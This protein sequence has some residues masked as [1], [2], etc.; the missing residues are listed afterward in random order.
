MK[1]VELKVGLFIIITTAIIIGF[2][3]FI[4]EKQ[5]LFEEGETL[6]LTTDSADGISSGMAVTFSGFKIGEI[7]AMKLEDSGKINLFVKIPSHHYKWIN[8][9]S[10]YILNKPLIGSTKILII[11]PDVNEK[12]LPKGK[13]MELLT[14]DSIDD[15]IQKIRPVVEKANEIL[16]NIEK[17]THTLSDKES[18]AAMATGDNSSG[19]DLA[20]ALSKSSK[21]IDS[22]DAT[23]I[24]A[25]NLV[26][27]TDKN[28]YG[29][30]GLM[31]DIRGEDGIISELRASLRKLDEM[32]AN[33][34]KISENV[35]SSSEDLE[36]LKSQIE[37]AIK[38]ANELILEIDSKIPFKDK[39]EIKLP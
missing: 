29:D 32:L 6:I 14:I 33:G 27:N 16:L 31:S 28:L 25:T 30:G 38:N 26:K 36:S 9:S 23:L 19:D 18:F 5:G 37:L 1:S 10:V 7:S 34:V 11:T 13:K 20:L 8:S 21:L 2:I 15:I 35:A 22:V 39:M 3:A 12:P 24:E 17:I 4:A